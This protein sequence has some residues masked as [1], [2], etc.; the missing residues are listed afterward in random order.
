MSY[1]VLKCKTTGRY[2]VRG[3]FL[4]YVNSTCKKPLLF[5]TRQTARKYQNV[6]RIRKKYNLT[7]DDFKVVK[8][9]VDMWEV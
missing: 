8:V 9:E 3:D 5:D 4:N 6:L 7:K 1:Y 2:V